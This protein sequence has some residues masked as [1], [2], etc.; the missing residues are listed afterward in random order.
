MRVVSLVPSLTELLHDLGLDEEVVG[1]TTFCVRPPGWSRTKARVGGT[2]TV[3]LEKVAALEPDL[4]LANQEENRREDVE[5]IAARFPTH[6]TRVA[7]VG[8]ALEM[9]R[10]VGGLVEREA[11]A[12]VVATQ[13]AAR[14]E[15]LGDLPPRR[16]SYLIWRD[17]WMVAG[18][19]TFIGDVMRRGGFV[20]AH[21]DGRR[22]P[23]VSAEELRAAAPEL[24]LLSSEPFPF[25]ERH[26][27]E[28][29]EAVPGARPVFVDGELFSWYGSRLLHTPAYL[30]SLAAPPVE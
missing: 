26:A 8:E 21:E 16:A 11:R 25:K 1:V 6:V 9:I 20:N 12:G 29:R 15:S 3:K 10:A 4:V 30:R 19:D 7:T 17:P 5:W 23:A 27:A 14:F 2:K 28:L 18:G 24:L 22:Y 13:V